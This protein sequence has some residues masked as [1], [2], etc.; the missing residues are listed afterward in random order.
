MIQREY[1]LVTVFGGAGFIGRYVCERLMEADVRVR[2]ACREP[3]LAHFIQPLGQIGQLGMVRADVTKPDSVRK[4][5]QGST[6]VINLVGAFK[7][8]R[9]VQSTGARHI[10]E[11]AAECGA[12]ALVHISAIGA[13]ADSPSEYG[14]SKAGGEEAVR[15]AFPTATILRPSVVFGSE[16][17]FTNRLARFGGLPFLPL[18]KPDCKLQPVFVEDLAKAIAAAALDPKAHGGK[19]YEIAG[20]NVMTMGE[21]A[22]T[23][24]RLSR[25]EA[26]PIELP[27]FAS[28]ALSWL[29]F[30]PG[31]PL[32]RDQWLMLQRHN[33]AAED[34]TGLE[35]FGITPTPLAAVAEEWLNRYWRGG[36]FAMRTA[37]DNPA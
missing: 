7:H 37:T 26:E 34:A 2:V 8:M 6:A 3:R 28:S 21:I 12:K 1:Q 10:A 9:A 31:A 23:V 20:P 15:S 27:N 29:G 35:A 16:D 18:I 25:Q 5:V 24:L 30:M 11:A 13:D 19:T 4:A 32:T 36:R 22:E 17:D 33:V 14:R